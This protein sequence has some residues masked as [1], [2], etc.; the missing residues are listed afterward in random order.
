MISDCYQSQ[1][2]VLTSKYFFVWVLFI[3]SSFIGIKRFM[4][5]WVAVFK[6][7]EVLWLLS[8]ACIT[9]T[10]VLIVSDRRPWMDEL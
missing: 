3:I 1:G 5:G 2:D 9:L 10:E 6:I 7:A 4:D 8:Y